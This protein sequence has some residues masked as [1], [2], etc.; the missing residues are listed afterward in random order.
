M[1][2]H[3]YSCNPLT[4]KVI[5]TGLCNQQYICQVSRFSGGLGTRSHFLER[6]WVMSRVRRNRNCVQRSGVMS[7]ATAQGRRRPP[8]RCGEVSAAGREGRLDDLG[9]AKRATP[10]P[11]EN[12][13]ERERDVI[14][15]SH[16]HKSKKAAMF[17]F[18]NSLFTIGLL[19]LPSSPSGSQGQF[20]L[21]HEREHGRENERQNEEQLE[22]QFAG[23]QQRQLARQLD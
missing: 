8:L 1:G 16:R 17:L 12:G 11:C 4:R 10:S 3:Y 14:L 19:T 21:Q 15:E 18:L 22:R 7:R 9:R 5:Q 20:G 2:T 23:Q 13:P 6:K